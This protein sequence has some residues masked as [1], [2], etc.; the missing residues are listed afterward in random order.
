[1]RKYDLVIGLV[2]AWM[3]WVGNGRA[4]TPVEGFSTDKECFSALRLAQQREAD[5]LRISGLRVIEEGARMRVGDEE[6]RSA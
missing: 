2:L 4:W 3:M 6:W 5:Q 1:M